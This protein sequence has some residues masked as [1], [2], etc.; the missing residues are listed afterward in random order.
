[1][2][3]ERW[4]VISR[5]S[6]ALQPPETDR[7]CLHGIVSGHTRCA[8]GKEITTSLVVSRNGSRV[9]TKSGSE[10]ELGVADPAYESLFPNARQRLFARL[11]SL[12]GVL[13]NAYE[14]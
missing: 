5:S 6:P 7:V 4:C 1:M 3:L 2:K 12:A 13:A 10:Y 8:D 11:R 9:V 14:I